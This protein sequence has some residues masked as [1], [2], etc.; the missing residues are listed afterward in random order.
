MDVHSRAG[1]ES[2][3]PRFEACP[4]VPFLVPFRYTIEPTRLYEILNVAAAALDGCV[5][6][7]ASS[8]SPPLLVQRE[9]HWV[10]RHD[11]H[12]DL[13]LCFLKLVKIASHHNA[14]LVLMREGYAQEVYAL[15][16]MIDEADQDAL[17]M[18]VPAGENDQ[19]SPNQLR[20]FKEFF[21]EEFTGAD[22]V[23]S[24]QSRD[25]VPREKVRAA[26]SR[27]YQGPTNDPSRE[28]LVGRTLS[29]AFSGFVHGAYVHVM[30][31]FGGS[32]GRYQTR[33]QLET[34]RI[35]ECLGNHVNHLYRSLLTAEQVAHR[36][37]RE[38]VVHAAL[39]ASIAL[40]RQTKCVAEERIKVM[41]ARRQRPLVKPT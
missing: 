15:C 31:L 23:E 17:F 26:I 8:I 10:F 30:E 36:A 21:Q 3:P 19:P 25:R 40:A 14:A 13:L 39:D 2:S 37:E 4:S 11:V 1:L 6:A 22:L 28:I 9:D 5:Q 29:G 32:P 33:G 12:D 24:Q 34:V 20:F 41:E 38:D 7:L 18:S 16:R 27:L 35:R